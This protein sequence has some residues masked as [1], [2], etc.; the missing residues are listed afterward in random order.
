MDVC[1]WVTY[2]AHIQREIDCTSD[3]IKTIWLKYLILSGQERKH[4]EAV[5][6]TNFIAADNRYGLGIQTVV[7]DSFPVAEELFL[8][9][10]GVEFD[11][12]KKDQAETSIDKDFPR[13]RTLTE[14]WCR[15]LGRTSKVSDTMLK[16]IALLSNSSHLSQTEQW[17]QDFLSTLRGFLAALNYNDDPNNRC[18]KQDDLTVALLTM[19][20]NTKKAS[21]ENLHVVHAIFG[22]QSMGSHDESQGKYIIKDRVMRAFNNDSGNEK[23]VGA[24]R[25]NGYSIVFSDPVSEKE[26]VDQQGRILFDRQHHVTGNHRKPYLVLL[27]DNP[28]LEGED[29]TALDGLGRKLIPLNYVFLYISIYTPE[30]NK[31]AILPR[32]LM[33]DILT[34]RN[35]IMRLLEEDFN[36]DLMEKNAE[37]LQEKIIL[38]RERSARH[39]STT[40]DVGVLRVFGLSSVSGMKTL[41]YPVSL[42]PPNPILDEPGYRLPDETGQYQQVFPGY[43]Y[44]ADL[45]L[46]LQSYVNAQIARL[47]SR[48]FNEKDKELVKN[49]GIPALY[50]SRADEQAEDVFKQRAETFGDLG[51]TP[52]APSQDNRFVLLNKAVTFYFDVPLDSPMACHENEWYNAEYIRCI[53]LDVVL[54]AIKHATVDDSLLSRVDTLVYEKKCGLEDRQ[55]IA[56]ELSR[57]FDPK[58][59]PAPTASHIFMFRDGLC[60]IILNNVNHAVLHRDT[61]TINEEIFRRTHDVL[62]YGD[63]HMSLFTIRHFIRGLWGRCADAPDS[64]FR[65]IT[66]ETLMNNYAGQKAVQ[67]HSD[68]IQMYDTWFETR[69]PIF[70]EEILDGQKTNLD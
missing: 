8:T 59:I 55:S 61:T 28:D 33:R 23:I 5:P 37:F 70:K 65:Y 67:G 50:L 68:T 56:P 1:F 31:R 16:W 48:H 52:S 15:W 10:S 30:E 6:D 66:K 36:G 26:Y 14:T 3:E 4:A 41:Q 54:S 21:I 27:F 17:Y 60:L 11:R 22:N 57:L 35:R 13:Y 64:S 40:D 25:K 12:F 39:A 43:P 7:T 9:T 42:E 53:L 45:W 46:L 69:L 24:L 18:L 29:S 63:G 51:I 44:S 32:I 2:L 49:E 34:Y 19:S 62:D 38:T 47:F 58:D 20:R